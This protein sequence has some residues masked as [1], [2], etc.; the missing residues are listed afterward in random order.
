VKTSG[1]IQ[2]KTSNSNIALKTA[3]RRTKSKAERNF[4]RFKEKMKQKSL[5]LTKMPIYHDDL[6][7]CNILK[8]HSTKDIN[9]NQVNKAS[10][11]GKTIPLHSKE[12]SLLGTKVLLHAKEIPLPDKKASITGKEISLPE[13]ETLL[14]G[15]ETTMHGEDSSI[16]E[17]EISLHGK[18]ES[19]LS[20]EI[21]LPD[22]ETP[23]PEKDIS[24]TGKEISLPEMETSLDCKETSIHGKDSSIPG[25]EILL[26]KEEA[27]LDGKETSIHNK[28]PSLDFKDTC[29]NAPT[30]LI[31]NE[32][33][34]FEEFNYDAPLDLYHDV[35]KKLP[36][37]SKPVKV[38]DEYH[39]SVVS[40]D[41]IFKQAKRQIDYD[42]VSN[43]EYSK[44]PNFYIENRDSSFSSLVSENSLIRKEDEHIFIKKEYE[45]MIMYQKLVSGSTKLIEHAIIKDKQDFSK[46]ATSSNTAEKLRILEA[47]AVKQVD[48]LDPN[49]V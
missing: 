3:T 41:D 34:D 28:E 22:K 6:L 10:F 30:R 14:D 35:I 39:D 47:I 13:K 7:E 25:K 32:S 44:R 36:K 17:K 12:E 29:K 49:Y 8:S 40:F 38:F 4:L 48:I 20:K 21:P 45:N 15:K 19:S 26:P 33:S 2:S 31:K 5:I 42:P 9:T 46:Y 16:P 43:S 37:T 18:K 27:S 24:L 11:S 1:E 23:L